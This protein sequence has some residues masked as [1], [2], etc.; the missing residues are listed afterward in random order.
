MT[1][2]PRPK[3]PGRRSYGFLKIK[4]GAATFV[5]LPWGEGGER[6]EPGEGVRTLL[7]QE[8]PHPDP[9]PSQV[10][11]IRLGHSIVPISG[12]PEIGG[13]REKNSN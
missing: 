1:T 2:R 9:L 6:S 3:T 5:P 4:S 11:S 7:G 13:E 10:G 8:P 12:K